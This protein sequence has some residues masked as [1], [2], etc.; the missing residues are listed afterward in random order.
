MDAVL[1]QILRSLDSQAGMLRRT[2]DG[3]KEEQF[4]RSPGETAPP[5]GWH[6]WHVARWGDRFQA[7]LANR[8][9]PVE[10]WVSEHMSEACGFSP[11]DLGILELGMGMEASKA[12]ALP[13]AIGKQRFESY[14]ERVLEALRAA[15]DGSEPATLLAPRMSIREYATVN[16]AI[17]YAP[18]QE[19]TLF[20]D[21]MFHLT[22][23]SRH[24]GSVEAL[25]GLS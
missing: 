7:T 15:I 9:A 21:V 24:L 22:H 11:D 23:S 16:G 4:A 19:S 1:E 10:I 3:M 8:D 25:R 6:V 13:A 5:M 14:L 20:A 17:Q 12:Q 18:S 2:L